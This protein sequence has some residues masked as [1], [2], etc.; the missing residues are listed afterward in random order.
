MSV[1]INSLND[2]PRRFGAKKGDACPEEGS[3]LNLDVD[4]LGGGNEGEAGVGE[5]AAQAEGSLISAT[6][7]RRQSACDKS[8]FDFTGSLSNRQQ[9]TQDQTMSGDSAGAGG[10]G[11]DGTV[12]VSVSSSARKKRGSFFYSWRERGSNR[13][14][15]DPCLLVGRDIEKKLLK[16][17]Y[18]CIRRPI[19]GSISEVE[20]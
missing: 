5:A 6:R 4:L 14:S 10:G 18:G 12:T 20:V 13:L 15:I 2:M 3:I 11:G 16:Q 7:G 19:H 1:S 8:Y 9:T 17:V